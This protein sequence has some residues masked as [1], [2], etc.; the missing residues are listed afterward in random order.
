MKPRLWRALGVALLAAFAVALGMLAVFLS[1]RLAGLVLA[2]LVLA[3]ALILYREIERAANLSARHE[4]VQK[5][6]AETA[7]NLEHAR[8]TDT[9]TRLSNRMR[10]FE[11]LQSEFRRSVRYDRPLSCI[12]IDLDR[13]AWINEQYGEHFGDTV[14]IQF[15]SLLARDLRETDLAVRF[16]GETFALLLPETSAAQAV[17][18]AERTRA[19]L[20][21]HVFSNGVVACSLTCSFGVSGLPDPRFARI[22]DLVHRATQALMEAKRRGRDR[23]VLDAAVSDEGEPL[24]APLPPNAFNEAR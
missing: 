18:V 10:F 3:L 4:T 13:F 23:V 7:S 15:A 8:A 2:L 14:L 21:E 12:M 20:K 5:Q 6:L 1:A 16:E 24:P 22:D 19:R 9:M 17:A 11:R